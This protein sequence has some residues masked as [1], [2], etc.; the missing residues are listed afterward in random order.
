MKEELV[1]QIRKDIE[2]L[3]DLLKDEEDTLRI[4]KKLEDNEQVQMYL[5][6]RDLD[7]VDDNEY[8]RKTFS[9][10]NIQVST[11]KKDFDI[12]DEELIRNI[13][14]ERYPWRISDEDTNGIYVYN[15]TFID[16]TFKRGYAKPVKTI[17]KPLRGLRTY[18]NI[19]TGHRKTIN[20]KDAATFESE[21][22]IIYP[23]NINADESQIYNL[24]E[25]VQ[26][27]F[28]YYVYS[29]DQNEAVQKLTQ[30]YK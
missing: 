10:Y 7:R 13:Y 19:E 6:F 23:K 5:N 21:H 11:E 29:M 2:T 16:G 3:K 28:Y 15:G 20:I 1:K 24:F 25:D 4:I 14:F 30:K 27:D 18:Q 12:T 9:K 17:L 22:T 26:S 8:I